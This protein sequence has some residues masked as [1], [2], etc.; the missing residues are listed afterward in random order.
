MHRVELPAPNTPLPGTALHQALLATLV[1]QY[2][3]DARIGAL[4]IFG[5]L[6]RDDWDTF[7]DLDLA[8][9]R[10]PEAKIDVA[11]E[12]AAIYRSLHERGHPVLFTQVAGSD[13]YL[14]LQELTGI[15]ISFHRLDE[16]DPGIADGM[17]V[18]CGVLSPTAIVAAAQANQREPLAAIGELHRFLWLALDA[19]IKLQ[20]RQFWNALPTLNR[21]RDALVAIF[22]VTR[23]AQRTYRFFEAEASA[24][25]KAA[26]GPT[27]PHYDAADPN[28]ALRAQSDA[29]DHSLRLLEYN[30]NEL[31][32]GQLVL[33]AGETETIQ[34][35]RERQHTLFPTT[36]ALQPW[37]CPT[38]SAPPA[39]GR[40]AAR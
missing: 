34:R 29:L 5:S 27:L 1:D 11:M 2:C 26:F 36:A 31:S 13:G 9:I 14:L 21:M 20:R 17:R 37:R 22:A 30:L 23:G 28:A 35:L 19:D 40:A 12:V 39:A 38:C 3:D 15:A 4:V 33:G 8:A 6:A 18:L 24:S 32:N 7:S 10:Q 25:L 16:A